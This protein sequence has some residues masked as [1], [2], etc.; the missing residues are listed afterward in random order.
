[1]LGIDILQI[2]QVKKIY[3]KHEGLFLEKVLNAR[4]IEELS[5]KNKRAFFRDLSYAIAAKE[6]IFKALSDDRL[7]WK[8]IM[9]LGLPEKIDVRIRQKD[10]N[11]KIALTFSCARDMVIAQA[12]A[13]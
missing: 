8:D 6:A 2:E 7:F 5:H 4:E 12:I 1:M 9:I 11:Q 13:F 10:Y 3:Q